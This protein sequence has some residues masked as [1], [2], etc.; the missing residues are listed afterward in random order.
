RAEL[1]NGFSISHLLAPHWK[2]LAMGMAAVGAETAAGLLEPWPLKVVL[3]SVLHAKKA[4]DWLSRVIMNLMGQDK[5]AVLKFAAVAVIV[6]AA[7]GAIGTYIEKRTITEVGQR[8][9]HEL[10]RTFYWHIQRLSMAYHDHKQSG[11]LISTVTTDIDSIQSAITSGILDFLYYALTLLGMMCVMFYLDWRFTLIALS[12]L[13]ALFIVV[14]T[15]TR[16]IKKASRAVR[17]KE[18]EIVSTLQEVLS[19]IRIVKAFAR[20]EYEQD[21]FEAE[22]TESVDL[23]LKARNIKAKLTPAV[24]ILVAA[25]TALVLWF[26]ARQVLNGDL[27]PGVLVV[28]F[29]YLGKMYKPMR[30]LSKMS[31]TYSKAIV[32]YDRIK[33]FLAIDVQVKDLPDARLAPAFKGEIEFEH[34]NF[35]YLPEHPVLKDINL[36]IQPGQVAALVGPTGCGKSTLISLIPRFYDPQSGSI[37]IDGVDVRRFKRRGLRQQMSFVLQETLLFRAPIWQNIAYGKPEATRDEMIHAAQ[38]AN[39]DEFIRRLPQGYD[40]MVGE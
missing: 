13:P 2:A 32:G 11:D 39:A 33:E 18:A 40:T 26:G 14:Y 28:F 4:P 19:S 31:D 6:I 1:E 9:M 10:R 5:L 35:S 37:K 25:G 21:R 3:D 29:L 15:F 20:E 7:L 27:T 23:A 16:R 34:V 17:K 38:L 22:S 8:V 12:I 24:D 36:K 30:E